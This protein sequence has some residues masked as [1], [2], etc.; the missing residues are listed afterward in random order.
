[1][2]RSATE[3]VIRVLYREARQ[4]VRYSAEWYAVQPRIATAVMVW[5][6][7]NTLRIVDTPNQPAL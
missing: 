1:M 2:N 4:H 3:N 6:M 7:D 5:R